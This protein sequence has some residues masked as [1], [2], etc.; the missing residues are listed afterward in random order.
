[1]PYP[2]KL[3]GW[4]E[5]I[6]CLLQLCLK[7][8]EKVNLG[9]RFRNLPQIANWSWVRH[10]P[11]ALRFDNIVNLL[12]HELVVYPVRSP[13]WIWQLHDT[14]EVLSEL[15]GQLLSLL[16]SSRANIANLCFPLP[17]SRLTALPCLKL[18]LNLWL[19]S[20]LRTVACAPVPCC[21]TGWKYF[22]DS[23]M[24]SEDANIECR[25]FQK[26]GS[27]TETELQT[28]EL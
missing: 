4:G 15:H 18:T 7:K 2:A 26:R 28:Y 3:F 9:R 24:F 10:S 25:I 17:E 21:W 13:L 20:K 23:W 16:S 22:R 12:L 27:S 8:A 6:A 5:K 1:M 14:D 11:S 19:Y